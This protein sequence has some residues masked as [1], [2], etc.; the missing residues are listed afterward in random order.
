M[1]LLNR[2]PGFPAEP[3]G[4]E[5]R[6]LRAL[7]K[8]TLMGTLILLLPALVSRFVED[9]SAEAI[10]TVASADIF[11]ASLI[12]LHWAVMFTAGLAGLIVMIMKGPGYVADAYPL[13]DSD[14][15]VDRRRKR[16]ES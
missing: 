12:F 7:P 5:R 4:L 13:V 15:P 8:I 10:K 14:K 6:I 16:R 3:A 1:R 2:L 9:G 11:S